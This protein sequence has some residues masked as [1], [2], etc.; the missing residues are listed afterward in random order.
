MDAAT[1]RRCRPPR[2]WQQ[3]QQQKQ[4]WLKDLPAAATERGRRKEGREEKALEPKWAMTDFILRINWSGRTGSW[5]VKLVTI[6]L[7]QLHARYIRTRWKPRLKKVVFFP[8][9]QNIFMKW[10]LNVITNHLISF[11][12]FDKICFGVRDPKWL[13]QQQRRI[14]SDRGK[15]AFFLTPLVYIRK[16]RSPIEGILYWSAESAPDEQEGSA[17]SN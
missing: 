12:S 13:R 2:S 16:R 17:T 1:R 7:L 15:K 14:I 11:N 8:V 3:L 4:L 6:V 9:S 5:L 10:R